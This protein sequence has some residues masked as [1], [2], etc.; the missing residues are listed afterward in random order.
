[1][2]GLAAQPTPSGHVKNITNDHNFSL[3]IPTEE[4][5][6]NEQRKKENL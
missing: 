1:M 6:K 5:F 3:L 2:A 4:N